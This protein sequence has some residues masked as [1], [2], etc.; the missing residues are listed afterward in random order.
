MKKISI[1]LILTTLFIFSCADAGGSSGS[2]SGDASF[3]MVGELHFSVPGADI[4]LTLSTGNLQSIS[5]NAGTTTV[6]GQHAGT[7]SPVDI[8][9]V[10][11]GE[12]YTYTVV[13]SSG[14]NV[15]NVGD[16]EKYRI[17]TITN[18]SILMELDLDND[19]TYEQE[20]IF[21]KQ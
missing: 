7:L 4:I 16:I 18:N 21:T 3:N 9:S 17:K 10:K 12:V 15:P 5:Y 11:V 2:S 6:M 14:S 20:A 8:S 19:G 1:I 13:S